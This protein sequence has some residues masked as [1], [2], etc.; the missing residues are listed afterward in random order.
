MVNC[1]DTSASHPSHPASDI[2][3]NLNS[4]PIELTI[5]E[6]LTGT[7]QSDLGRPLVKANNDDPLQP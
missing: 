4:I 1:G 7:V 5:K 2:L 3:T 6:I